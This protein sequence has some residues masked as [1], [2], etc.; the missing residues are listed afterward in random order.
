[1]PPKNFDG[2]ED[3]I[4]FEELA[5]V[6]KLK[7]RDESVVALKSVSLNNGNEFYPIKK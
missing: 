7:G 4:Y 6:Y 3:M 5:K 1:L 2:K